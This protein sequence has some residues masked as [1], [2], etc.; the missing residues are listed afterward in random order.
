MHRMSRSLTVAAVA[1]IVTLQVAA[2]QAQP[3]AKPGPA[4]AR[5]AYF[6]GKWKAEGEVKPGP[7]GPGGKITT[8]DDCQWFEGKF[9]VICRSEG[10]T[11]NGPTRSI[12][13]LGYSTEEKVYTYYGVDNSGMTMSSVPKGTIQGD[14]WTYT[15]ESTMGGQKVKSRVTIKEVSPKSYTF[16]MEFQGPDGKWMPAMETTNTKVQ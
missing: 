2:G 8:T 3:P 9:S 15:D 6:V 4:Q 13:I 14:T 11:P 5:L 12:G 16:R 7:M 1:S 10:T